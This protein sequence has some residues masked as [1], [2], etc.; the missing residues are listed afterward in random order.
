M[1]ARSY[2]VFDLLEYIGARMQGKVEY[3]DALFDSQ[4][5]CSISKD[6]IDERI[7]LPEIAGIQ[8]RSFKNGVWLSASTYQMEKTRL[9]ELMK[10]LVRPGP[11]VANEIKLGELEPSKLNVTMPLKKDPA[12]AR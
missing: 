4:S 6:N 8:L 12:R 3:W 10:Y 1:T 11:K 7:S 2:D 9:G 5:S